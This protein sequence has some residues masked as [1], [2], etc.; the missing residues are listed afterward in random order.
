M[1]PNCKLQGRGR[2][3]HTHTHTNTLPYRAALSQQQ[4]VDRF[5]ALRVLS[6]LHSP[7]LRC[8][9]SPNTM[10]QDH[11]NKNVATRKTELRR[12]ELRE[13]SGFNLL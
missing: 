1:S 7:D 4:S 8:S 9:A 3:S 11:G 2:T 6:C 13:T 12:V 5:A 10:L